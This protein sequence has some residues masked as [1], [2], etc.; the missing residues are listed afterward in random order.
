MDENIEKLRRLKIAGDKVLKQISTLEKELAALKVKQVDA[1]TKLDLLREKHGPESQ[2]YSEKSTEFKAMRSK[3]EKCRLFYNKAVS[4]FTEIAFG[5]SGLFETLIW[6]L[7]NDQFIDYKNK[8]ARSIRDLVD[9]DFAAERMASETKPVQAF[10]QCI[11]GC[12]YNFET[13]NPDFNICKINLRLVSELVKDQ[14]DLE[15]FWEIKT[16]AI[17]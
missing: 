2:I 15:S 17:K 13:K 16:R 4:E 14:P 11:M 10:L 9:S 12:K 3:I 8:V 7:L 5:G 6:P 1:K